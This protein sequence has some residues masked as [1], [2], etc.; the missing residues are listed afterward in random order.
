[1]YTAAILMIRHGISGIPVIRNQKLMGIIT[2]SDIVNV[3]ASKG[4]LN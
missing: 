4:K 3:L 1:V 2:K